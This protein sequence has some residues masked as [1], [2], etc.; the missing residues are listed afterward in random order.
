[1]IRILSFSFYRLWPKSKFRRV[2]D[3]LLVVGP[4]ADAVDHRKTELALRQV[5]AEALVLGV[6]QRNQTRLNA[7]TKNR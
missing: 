5:L 3:D 6:L 4:D 1:M 7:N 2:P